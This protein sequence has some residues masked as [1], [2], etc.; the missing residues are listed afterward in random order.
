MLI[1]QNLLQELYDDAGFERTKKAKQYAKENKI[2]ILKMN[3]DDPNNFDISSDVKGIHDEYRVNVC[4]KNA[5]LEVASCECKDYEKTYGVCKHILATIIRLNQ[6]KFWENHEKTRQN[7]NISDALKSQDFE[8]VINE[9][10]NE[11]LREINSENLEELPNNLKV[12]LEPKI[13]FDRIDSDLK[14]EFKIGNNRMYKI[15]DLSEFYTRVINNEFYKYGE[16]LEFL[17]NVNNFEEKSIPLLKFI[18]KYSEILKNVVK[19]ERYS[20]YYSSNVSQPYLTLGNNTIDEAFD[21][22]KNKNVIYEYDYISNKMN[23]IEGD[24][25]IQFSMKKIGDGTF[26]FAPNIDIYEI[27]IFKGEKYDYLL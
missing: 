25:P 12:K 4:V 18:L 22:L 27:R 2:D 15:K 23:F 1:N 24:P 10:Y 11:Q 5:E 6:T 14:L 13:I 9:F 7:K 3:Y 19:R 20:Y 16:K 8:K 26:K 17:H 21:L